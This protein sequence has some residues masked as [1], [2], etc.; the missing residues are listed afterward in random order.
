MLDAAERLLPDVRAAARVA[1]QARRPLLL[2]LDAPEE[3]PP[4]LAARAGAW[5]AD[6]AAQL[7]ESG[8]R[9]ALGCGPEFWEQAG[10]GLDAR[11]V[12]L[13]P[14]PPPPRP[15]WGSAG[16]CPPAPIR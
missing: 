16:P 10:S 12:P 1:A 11:V 3:M 14:L 8:I 7:R 5:L 4:A 2:A 6:S 15:R 13:G 9:W